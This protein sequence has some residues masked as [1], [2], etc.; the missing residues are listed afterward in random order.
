MAEVTREALEYLVE[1]GKK[2][3]QVER[4]TI[5]G[6]EYTRQEIKP[7]KSESRT[8][9]Q[10]TTL[11][12]LADLCVNKFGDTSQTLGFEGFN[13]A[14]HVVH[15]VNEKNVQLVTANSDEWARREVLIDCKLTE[16]QEFPFGKFLSQDE[17]II[18]VLSSCVPDLDRDY[19]AKLAG[20]ALAEAIS[21]SQDDG[22][23]QTMSTKHGA[24][25][26]TQETIKN[27]VEVRMY[28]TFREVEQPKTKMLFRLKQ[29]GDNLP[30][31]AFFPCDGGAWKLE[32]LEN[33]ARCLRTSIPAA[34]VAS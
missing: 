13:P 17:F 34:V 20:N 6:R 14:M 11:R 15:V 9:L 24:H 27:V 10:V 19:V 8:A 3:S 25:L 16:T 33:V 29:S 4:L 21:H 22:V 12:A 26:Q 30:T 5:D 18:A 32:A 1:Q 28:R 2:L 31:F 7:V 23:S